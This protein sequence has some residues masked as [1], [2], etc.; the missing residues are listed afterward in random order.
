M[1]SAHCGQAPCRCCGNP[2]PDNRLGG[3]ARTQ[4]TGEEAEARET[5]DC[6]KATELP[7]GFPGTYIYVS[8]YKLRAGPQSHTFLTASFSPQGPRKE[9]LCCQILF[10][11][12]PQSVWLGH[13]SELP[14]AFLRGKV[15]RFASDRSRN[16]NRASGRTPGPPSPGL[17]GVRELMET[18][19]SPGPHLRD[20]HAADSLAQTFPGDSEGR[21]WSLGVP[22]SG[23]LSPEAWQLWLKGTSHCIYLFSLQTEIII[24]PPC[25]LLPS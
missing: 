1:V 7:T 11:S 9:I 2:D 8:D 18:K 23:A 19:G 25:P 22:E 15:L 20:V 13:Q 16:R 6:P 10:Y 3:P 21:L 4:L 12:S 14:I 17:G 5:G 24:I